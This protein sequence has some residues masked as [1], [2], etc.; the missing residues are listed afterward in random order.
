MTHFIDITRPVTKNL[1]SWPGRLPPEHHWDKSIA[2]G[3]HCNASF[4]KMSAHSGTHMDAPLHFIEGGR[5]IDQIPPDVFI[6]VCTVID[7]PAMNC[8]VMDDALASQFRGEKRLLIRTHHSD[9]GS[10]VIYQPHDALLTSEA[11]SI[12]IDG[13]LMLIGTD[14]LSVDDSRGADYALHHLLL[15]ASCVIVEGLHLAKVTPG[16][17]SLIAAP[18]R[19]T[20]KEASPVRALLFEM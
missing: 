6:G 4:W 14:R 19:L 10:E 3:D 2:Q 11:A 7:L 16:R 15:K 8:S 12:L 9:A 20:G 17:Y 18:L 5:A 1:I 13:G